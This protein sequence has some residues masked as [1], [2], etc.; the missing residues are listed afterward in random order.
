MKSME[1]HRLPQNG[2]ATYGILLDG[3]TLIPFA[4]T[5]ELPWADNIKNVSC[6]PYGHYNCQRHTRP[7]GDVT[8]EIM[9]VRNRTNILFHV[10]NYTSDLKGCIGIGE[11]FAVL[12][13]GEGI[14]YS[15]NGFKEFM[16]KLDGENYFQLE[17]K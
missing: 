12:P 9:D 8:F 14:A 4:V 13:K 6:I 16:K 7:N 10:A 11:S 17:I 3:D 1:L 2:T 5:L 15:S